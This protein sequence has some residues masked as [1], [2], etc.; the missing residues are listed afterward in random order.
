MWTDDAEP[1]RAAGTANALEG[2]KQDVYAFAFFDATDVQNGLIAVRL[3]AGRME[4]VPVHAVVECRDSSFRF[5]EVFERMAFDEIRHRQ[6]TCARAK[7]GTEQGPIDAAV[8]ACPPVPHAVQRQHVP[9]AWR[10]HMGKVQPGW[11]AVMMDDLRRQASH[12]RRSAGEIPRAPEDN[13]LL[14]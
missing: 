7:R 8:D 11:T 4:R 9:R 5:R 10:A 6:H 12:Q 2:V 14:S 3:D 1:R 13:R